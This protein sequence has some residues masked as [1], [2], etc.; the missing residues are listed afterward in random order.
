MFRSIHILTGET[1]YERPPQSQAEF[2]T[3]LN[4][5]RQRQRHFAAQPVTARTALLSAFAQR[6]DAERG[7]LARMVSEEVGRC[8]TECR[9]E[10]DKSVE[11]IRY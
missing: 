10:L 4:A 3:A 2:Q 11:L 9:A 6:L 8:L 1:L 5:L 7:R